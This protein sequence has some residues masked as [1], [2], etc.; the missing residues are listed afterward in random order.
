MVKF[1]DG[2]V[3]EIKEG[4]TQSTVSDYF[5]EEESQPVCPNPQPCPTPE[6][7]PD[8]QP[9][10]TPES[11]PDSEP[12]PTPE[13]EPEPTPEPEPEQTPEPDLEP[14]VV[15][16]EEGYTQDELNQLIQE[17]KNGNHEFRAR[18]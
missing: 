5:K 9:C 4:F 13:P 2:S 15:I 17:K 1:L 14:D 12:C 3:L 16:P 10:P 6:S 7:T 18:L 8:P 11:T